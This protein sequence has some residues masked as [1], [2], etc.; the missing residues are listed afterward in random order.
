LILLYVIK[1][2]RSRC[3]LKLGTILNNNTI[4]TYYISLIWLGGPWGSRRRQVRQC[5]VTFFN[6]CQRRVPL[7]NIL[8]AVFP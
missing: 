1:I 6:I 2:L 4:S 5:L 3:Q 8:H 7:N